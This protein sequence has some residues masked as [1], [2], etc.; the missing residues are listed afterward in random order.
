MSPTSPDPKLNRRSFLEGVAALSAVAA[1]PQLAAA[2]PA[3]PAPAAPGGPIVVS[4]MNGLTK[5]AAGRTAVETAFALINDAE[6]AKKRFATL[7]AVVSGLAVVEENPDDHS[8]GKGGLPNEEG[9]VQLDASVMDG[10]THRAGAVAAVEDIVN[11]ARLAMCVLRYTKHSFIVGAGAKKFALE[12]GF[13]QENLLTPEARA[14]WLYWRQRHSD[15]DDW[16][17][18]PDDEVPKSWVEAWTHGTIHMSALDGNGDFAAGTTT[19]GLSYKIPGR[20]GDSPVVGAGMYCDNALGSAGA[21]GRGEEAIVNCAAFSMVRLMGDGKTPTEAAREVMKRV[22]D[23]A[24]PRGFVGK[25]GKPNFDLTFYA[26]RKDGQYGSVT[27]WSGKDGG[28][29]FA[30]MD[31][32]GARLER[33]EPLFEG[34]AQNDA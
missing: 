20:V 29:K 7:D 24:V 10:K 25:N 30:V 19:S 6:H 8:V 2:A 12:L 15:R 5:D 32:R 22:A 31:A 27:M 14:M 16:I 34:S 13:Q 21:T 4:S 11:V 1:A 9:V 3:P 17:A 28:D 26:V 18:P 23:H 33:S